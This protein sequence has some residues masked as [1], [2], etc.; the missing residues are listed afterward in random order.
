MP[1]CH[2]ETNPQYRD[3]SYEQ[4]CTGQTGHI[5]VLFIELNEPEKHFEELIRFFFQFHDP[6]TSN[7][8]GNDRGLQYA[9]WIFCADDTQA[10]IAKKTRDELQKAIDQDLIKCFTGRTITTQISP[11]QHFTKAQE[12]HQMYLSKNPGGYCNHRMRFYDWP[13]SN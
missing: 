4:V 1:V 5:E 3:P 7:R 2:S 12:S 9:S 11:I 10:Q 6:T 13:K 8:Q